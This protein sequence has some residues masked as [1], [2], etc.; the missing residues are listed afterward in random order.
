MARKHNNRNSAQPT[1]IFEPLEGRQ[2]FAAG[3]QDPSFGVNGRAFA[4]F[5]GDGVGTAT[6][7]VVQ[8]DGKTVVVGTVAVKDFAGNTMHRFGVA[9]FNFDGTLD[10]TFGPDRNGTILIAMG[11]KNNANATGVALQADGRIVVVGS[12]EID[13]FLATDTREF[14]IARLTT[15][16]RLDNSFS[17][18]GKQLVR[19]KHD[20]FA[21]DVAIQPDGKI[22][23]VGGD[24][25]GGGLF[26][27][28]DFDFAIVRLN[29]NGSLDG[30]FAGGGKRIIGLGEMESAT[31]VAI[32]TNGTP[33][34]NRNFGKIVLAGNFAKGLSEQKYAM[35]RLL[36]NGQLDTKFSKDGS[37]TAAFPG[38]SQAFVNGVVIQ[39]NG[40]MVVS[41]HAS[42]G[43]FRGQTPIVLARHFSRD[44]DIDRSFG[45]D[46]N[47]SAYIDLRGDD[48]AS[49][50]IETS[51]GSLV[52]G[53]TS[54][55]RFALAKFSRDGVIDTS[56]GLFGTLIADP[57][58][59][60]VASSVG[61]ARLGNRLVVAGGKAFKTM[62]FL[63]TGA[64][65]VK[66]SD[67]V[68]GTA[69]GSA[70]LGTFVVQRSELLPIR[71]RVFFNISGTASADDYTLSGISK[72]GRTV[73]LPNGRTANVLPVNGSATHFVD[74]PAN[75]NFAVVTITAADD[76]VVE[77]QE[78]AV[79]TMAG[80]PV[81][82]PGNPS[83]AIINIGD[84]D[85][86]PAP[87]PRPAPLPQ[88]TQPRL[89]LF[90][91]TLITGLV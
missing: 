6:D 66:I 86:T 58:V 46:F 22:V 29:K 11:N 9:R 45:R 31:A 85:G 81:A 78:R 4:S 12:A 89:P 3:A 75:T 56:F 76:N 14:A 57:A 62:R 23:V 72:V 54:N 21:N 24:D 20:S 30:S 2:M 17:E 13:R 8:K 51:D 43:N 69:E 59:P 48:R 16:G 88:L 1:S 63:D 87:S 37:L 52:V 80:G 47:G 90:S 50:L 91:S 53:G 19:V 67:G 41:G 60:N 64:N 40:R 39:S 79:F 26:T 49:D 82:V 61:L 34:S 28:N 36:P 42:G 38:Y 83:V 5:P 33:A 10:R 73:S 18:D 25:N 70:T 32:D 27:N 84:N 77:G 15:S 35:V 44:G 68:R 71:T 74:I 55:G 65:V 7:V